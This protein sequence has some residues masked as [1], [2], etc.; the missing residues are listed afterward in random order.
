MMTNAPEH[1]SQDRKSAESFGCVLFGL[2]ALFPVGTARAKPFGKT[3]Q[4]ILTIFQIGCI[5]K[6]M[7]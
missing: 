7:A 6:F 4:P 2:P 3:A 5:I 1:I